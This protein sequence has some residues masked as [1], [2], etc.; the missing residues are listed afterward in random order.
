[1]LGFPSGCR[2]QGIFFDDVSEGDPK[3]RR[4]V[5]NPAA[6]SPTL[7]MHRFASPVSLFRDALEAARK[8]RTSVEGRDAGPLLALLKDGLS[9]LERTVS[10]VPTSADTPAACSLLIGGRC[11]ATLGALR[12]G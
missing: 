11:V 12:K 8:L 1:M 9:F 3:V 6:Q 10:S 4:H 2:R 5:Q 7:I